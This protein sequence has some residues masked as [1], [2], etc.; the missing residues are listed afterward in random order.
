MCEPCLLCKCTDTHKSYQLSAHAIAVCERCGFE[1]HPGFR[2]GGG[3]QET[4]SEEYY[5]EQHKNAFQ[6]QFGD[7]MRDPSAPVYQHWL[8]RI[9]ERI[10][11]GRMLDVGSAL[12]TFL[13]ISE[14]RGWTP[15][16][17]EVSRFASEFARRERRLNVFHGDLGDFGAAEESF[18]AITFW[19]S[20]EH[21][22]SPRENLETAARMLRGGG[23]ML[24]T[25]DNFDCLV[26]DT[27]RVAY[28]LSFGGFRYAMDKVFIDRNRSYFTEATLRSLLVTCGL[29]VVVF[30]K[31][32][33]PLNKV[34]VGPVERTLL[35]GFYAAAQLL[36]RE[37]QITVLA[38]KPHR[39]ATG[40]ARRL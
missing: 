16:G 30:E 26:A 8:G 7:Y 36:H 35:R 19:D 22:M 20:I 5:K 27:A 37:A 4:F 18:D 40:T 21:V 3:D 13:K 23:L 31:M 33:Y 24:L 15:E 14:G 2:G 29:R 12:G 32:E 11:K 10:P 39:L 17:V 28:R 38:E 9:E 1:Y 34:A 25:T 6:A